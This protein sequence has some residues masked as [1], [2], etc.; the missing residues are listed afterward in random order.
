[1]LFDTKQTLKQIVNIV[2]KELEQAEQQK[3]LEL[4]E[5]QELEQEKAEATAAAKSVSEVVDMI[6]QD[7]LAVAEKLGVELSDADIENMKIDS[8]KKPKSKAV[9]F[10]PSKKKKPAVNDED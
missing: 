10:E 1:M 6:K 8:P 9:K 2:S 7:P 3:Q 5:L 4:Q